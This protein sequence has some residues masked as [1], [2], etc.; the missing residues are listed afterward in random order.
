MMN[1][2]D[3]FGRFSS[4]FRL[5][6]QN[7][8]LH[9]PYL[10][11]LAPGLTRS[12]HQSRIR[13]GKADW[14]DHWQTPHFHQMMS[15]KSSSLVAI[16][17]SDIMSRYQSL[18]GNY[19]EWNLLIF[20]IMVFDENLLRCHISARLYVIKNVCAVVYKLKYS[21]LEIRSPTSARRSACLCFYLSLNIPFY[22]SKPRAYFYI[23]WAVH[24]KCTSNCETKYF[25]NRRKEAVTTLSK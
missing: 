2:N 24:I 21:F 1:G 13:S 20:P 6:M 18:T 19:Y 14:V 3:T 5:H 25:W 22:I 16:F 9:C 17:P 15:M 11:L 10:R 8:V 4:E 23:T 12:S 7:W